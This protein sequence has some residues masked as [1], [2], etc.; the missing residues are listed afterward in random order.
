[1]ENI[2]PN[3]VEYCISI[4]NKAIVF[5]SSIPFDIILLPLLKGLTIGK[6]TCSLKELHHF[7]IPHKDNNKSDVK[8]II[9]QTFE[10]ANIEEGEEY[11]DFG[12]YR[13]RDRV[14]LPKSLAKC[15]QDCETESIKVRH[16]YVC[17]KLS[18]VSF[19]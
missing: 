9:T 16:K 19:Y 15:V 5:G 8:T 13:L 2:W 18:I 4:P 17:V 11:E 10:C 7:T 6:I 3:K 1:M 12:K 14:G